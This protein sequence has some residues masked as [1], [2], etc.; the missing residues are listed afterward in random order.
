M[1]DRKLKILR[2]DYGLFDSSR[3]PYVLDPEHIPVDNH[4]TV[5][6]LQYLASLSDRI[7]FYNE[8]ETISG[9]WGQ[10]ITDY[11]PVSLA[12]YAKKS[13]D[14]VNQAY[15]HFLMEMDSAVSAT[16]KTEAVISF[17]ADTL[18]LT[19]PLYKWLLHYS[20][21]TNS[22][23]YEGIALELAQKIPKALDELWN[24]SK[25]DNNTVRRKK[26]S[27]EYD[28][29]RK[30]YTL[31][32]GDHPIVKLSHAPDPQGGSVV[33]SAEELAQLKE[34]FVDI[35]KMITSFVVFAQE[36]I[37]N[38]IT[39]KETAKPYFALVVSF[40]GR[41]DEL[42]TYMNGLTKRHLDFYYKQVLKLKKHTGV[43]DQTFVLFGLKK[44]LPSFELPLGTELLAGKD[45]AGKDLVYAT[46]NDI[47]VSATTITKLL[48]LYVER[49][50]FPYGKGTISFVKG[51]YA[52]FNPLIGSDG[53][54]M[55]TWPLLGCPIINTNFPDAAMEEA[56]LG[57]SIAS[58]EFFLSSGE[59]DVTVSFYLE[60]GKYFDEIVDYVKNIEKRNYDNTVYWLFF[61]AFKLTLTGE[62]GWIPV[63]YKF[64]YDKDNQ[65][66][67]ISFSLTGADPAIV[68]YSE[69]V[70]MA[71]IATNLPVLRLMLN[72]YD[73]PYY[74]YSLLESVTVKRIVISSS[75]TDI[76]NI[77]LFSNEGKLIP[78]KPFAPLGT[79]P[80]PGAYLMIGCAE[81]L[82]KKLD[83]LHI[84]IDW[85]NLPQNGFTEQYIGYPDPPTNSSFVVGLSLL[86]NGIFV[87]A[88]DKQQ[89]YNL[90]TDSPNDP[91]N[92][93]MLPY[94]DF[95]EIDLQLLHQLPTWNPAP[96][97]DY[98]P[99]VSEG[100]IRV[101][102]MQP[103][104]G[105][106]NSQYAS[107]LTNTIMLNTERSGVFSK[108]FPKIFP[109]LPPLPLPQPPFTP[110]ANSVSL[111]YTSSIDT[112]RLPVTGP[113]H[114]QF[115]FFYNNPFGTVSLVTQS[116]FNQLSLLPV[117][118]DE[119]Y[120]FMALDVLTQPAALSVFFNLS[121]ESFYIAEQL[122]TV[123][124]S[125]L[126]G[127]GWKPFTKEQII[128]DGTESF[129]GTGIVNMDIPSDIINTSSVM[130]AGSFWLSASIT[131]NSDVISP[132]YSISTQAV[133]V[134]WKNEG[135]DPHHL[136]QPLPPQSIVAF[137][138][139]TP[140][141]QSI[142]QPLASTGAVP[143]ENDRAY[144]IRVSER[145][146]HKKRAIQPL[147][148]ERIILQNFVQLYMVQCFPNAVYTDI[149]PQ[150]G[151]VLIIIM[152]KDDQHSLHDILSPKTDLAL[153]TSVS[154]YI[155]NYIPPGISVHVHNPVYEEVKV[156]CTVKFKTQYDSGFS[157]GQL[158][159]DLE[160]FIS[161]WLFDDNSLVKMGQTLSTSE[162]IGFIS[163]LS[164]V[165]FVTGLSI[166]VMTSLDNVFRL[167]DTARVPDTELDVILKNDEIQ[168][169]YPWSVFV[170][171]SSHRI[172]LAESNMLVPPTPR[173]IGNLEISDDFIID[174]I[175]TKDK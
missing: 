112:D 114:P 30:M 129:I 151:N 28:D 84:R 77:G 12:Q 116:R 162:M 26:I 80:N 128:N 20:Y 25:I 14:E 130:P 81:A 173:G 93:A 168:S 117:Y 86:Q 50:K 13:L 3:M 170:T 85:A 22:G 88:D 105:F 133:R 113:D 66:F 139:Q 34:A 146:Y 1:A 31:L 47:V 123:N 44:G 42:R 27:E 5:S 23:N 169:T 6:D 140:S 69:L 38:A 125:Y 147:D 115:Q 161:P 61:K 174:L 43:P 137:R 92:T 141:V 8:N 58:S 67:E 83:T 32:T 100:Y 132:A 107:A 103:S 96:L 149:D 119:G 24:L 59:R 122:P 46:D 45:A 18:E 17:F 157:L 94:T 57:F 131:S 68:A 101:E 165:E 144:Y 118:E 171:S 142:L 143:M 82:S 40:L 9:T 99:G 98:A 4:K 136:D 152:A 102:L 138:Q 29:F 106:G 10:F 175:P 11:G 95:S 126:S 78:G 64:L 48:N 19:K 158:N 166:E 172:K 163:Q 111:D 39:P 87:P 55:S 145:L 164:Y 150:P 109:P 53:L 16:K 90:F 56:Q 7:F 121:G 73:A 60:T 104:S 127:N 51:I 155:Q 134:T 167:R 71:G 62:K 120:L 41:L 108:L 89:K 15:C 148:Y 65:R 154:E 74:A 97:P 37:E 135:N 36:N 72:T 159:D 124:W 52:N 70:H 76:T 2:T 21:Q 35:Y 33:L 75:V 156:C 153:N 110:E 49:V 54:K 79:T 63:G 91:V 160:K